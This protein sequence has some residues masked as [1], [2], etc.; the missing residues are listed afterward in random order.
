MSYTNNAILCLVLACSVFFTA[1]P[2]HA[3]TANSLDITVSENGD[4]IATFRF[5][6]EGII[7]NS[8]PQ[9]MLEEELKKGLT[10]S[11]EPP[12]LMSMDKSSAVLLLKKFADTADVPTGIEYRT[13]TMDFK[14]AEIALQNSAISG[15]VSADFSPEKITL[16]FPDSFRREFSNVDVLPAVFHTVVDPSKTPRPTSIP[17]VTGTAVPGAT[18]VQ[19]IT[20][21][22]NVTSS[23][24][25]VKVF[26]GSRYIGDAPALFSGIVPGIYTVE[27][28]KDG[29]ESV[30]K[31]VTVNPQRT[32]SVMVVLRYIPPAA[33]EEPSAFPW[34]P[35]LAVMFCLA[36]IAT[37]GYFYWTEKKKKEWGVEEDT[38]PDCSQNPVPP[39]GGSTTKSPGAG[40]PA[41]GSPATGGPEAR[42]T[43]VRVT[44][45]RD[46]PDKGTGQKDSGDKPE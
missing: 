5:T 10:T 3:F 39:S 29:Y 30:S 11:A 13:A 15:A 31:N 38:G 4:A 34:L 19:P 27:F 35:V 6:L 12:E 45:L 2:A 20:G 24:P 44:M 14:K 9:S 18:T 1:I 23:P 43:V 41:T 25:G 22:M 32:T 16:T 40:S 42:N 37:G 46:N 28:R 7:E 8:I 33:T 21:S 36:A 17:G 26:L